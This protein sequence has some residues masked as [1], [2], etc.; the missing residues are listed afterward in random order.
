MGIVFPE[1]GRTDLP[2]LRRSIGSYYGIDRLGFP[3][4]GQQSSA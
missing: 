3:W 1:R 2:D 4:S